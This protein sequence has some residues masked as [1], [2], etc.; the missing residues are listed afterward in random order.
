MNSRWYRGIFRALLFCVAMHAAVFLLAFESYARVNPKAM[1]RNPQSLSNQVVKDGKLLKLKLANAVISNLTLQNVEVSMTEFENI[2]FEGCTFAKVDFDAVTFKN[3]LFKNCIFKEI[4]DTKDSSNR[5]KISG[6]AHDIMFDACELRNIEFSFSA[7]PTAYI[8]FK[9]IK[10]AY[11]VRENGPFIAWAGANVRLD[12]CSIQSGIIGGGEETTAMV[13][14]SSL[15]KA[16]IY[17]D[18]TFISKSKLT[19]GSDPGGRQIL[20]VTDSE[21]TGGT[22]QVK[23]VGYALNNAY[24]FFTAETPFGRKFIAGV[25]VKGGTPQDKI[26]ITGTPGEHSLRIFGGDVEVR[27]LKLIE[28]ILSQSLTTGPIGALHMKD[29]SIQGGSWRDLAL[30]GGR[31]ENVRIEPSIVA[32]KA[33]IK[34]VQ[35]Y[36][37]EYPKGNPFIFREDKQLE[38]DIKTVD[39]PFEWPEIVAPTPEEHGLIWWPEVEP[40]YRPQ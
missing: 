32:D 28:P 34:N 6:I 25:G 24:K 19:E 5:T 11:S 38:L 36:R 17:A 37:L 20:V 10:V 27:G 29:V 39:K 30:L 23:G 26:Y 4:G 8:L 12:N 1:E 40:G 3:V 18:K 15:A 9:N 14:N 13:K 22:L 16:D 2:T 33:S 35:A 7:K 21:L 31:W